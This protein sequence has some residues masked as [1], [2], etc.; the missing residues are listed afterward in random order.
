MSLI[1][2]A[3]ADVCGLDPTVKSA[4]R[5]ISSKA[6]ELA[7]ANPPYTPDEVREFGKRFWELCPYAR[8]KRDRPTP[9][10]IAKRIGLLRRKKKQNKPTPYKPEPIPP[11]LSA[12]D[13]EKVRQTIAS[14]ASKT[15]IPPKE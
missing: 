2:D 10:E 15:V 4:E 6:E 8:D 7:H 13:R 9:N 1:F 11:P 3:M 5:S 14:F 12:E